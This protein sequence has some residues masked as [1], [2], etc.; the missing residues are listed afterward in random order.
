[1]IGKVNFSDDFKRDAVAQSGT[2][3]EFFN[4]VGSVSGPVIAEVD[5]LRLAR[6]VTMR[7][8]RRG[9][10]R[11][12]EW[13]ARVGCVAPF[14]A[15]PLSALLT[16]S[17]IRRSKHCCFAP[18]FRSLRR[19]FAFR[20]SWHCRKLTSGSQCFRSLRHLSCGQ[21]LSKKP[22]VAI[23][24]SGANAKSF[25]RPNPAVYGSHVASCVNAMSIA[26]P[27]SISTT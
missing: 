22:S 6:M 23:L 2:G 10:S 20:E 14:D 21:N 13:P 17:P 27:S 7:K 11:R 12:D 4:K 16:G 5:L 18:S 15:G 1:M 8:L 19:F 3:F 26:S 25:Y 24:Q 9:C